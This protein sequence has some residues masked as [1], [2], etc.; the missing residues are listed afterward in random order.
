L[1][2]GVTG[3]PGVGSTVV[4]SNTPTISSPTLL[5]A[6]LAN[7]THFTN[8]ID[9]YNNITTAGNGVSSEIFQTLNAGLVANYNAGAAKTLFTPTA[10]AMYRISF[11]QSIQQAATTSSTTPSLTLSYTDAGGVARTLV[12]VTSDSSNLT[13]S[14]PQQGNVHIY[15][16]GSTAVTI[17][18][19]G[20]ASSGATAMQYVL[21]VTAEAL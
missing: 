17:T 6:T 2:D 14:A 18:S 5:G 13:T 20:Y 19:S 8:K 15:T 3:T 4:L 16:N 12:L 21:A 7:A 11:F 1:S 9:K 10:A